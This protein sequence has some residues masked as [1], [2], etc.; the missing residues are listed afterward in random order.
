[1]IR[2]LCVGN[3]YQVDDGVGPA[4]GRWLIEHCSLPT[5]VEVLDRATMGY[6]MV[7]DLMGCDAVVVVDAVDGT[8]E[9]PGTVVRFVPDD[10]APSSG[11][12]SLHDVRFADVWNNAQFMGCTC[13]SAVCFGVQVLD[14]GDGTMR[15]GM[16]EPVAAAVEPCARAVIAYLRDELGCDIALRV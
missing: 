5:E 13:D 14:L 8:G 6:A 15:Q 11:M 2:V 12:T 1:M 3:E 16:T 7:G 10:M 9:A 4:V